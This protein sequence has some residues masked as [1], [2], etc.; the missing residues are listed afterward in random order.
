MDIPSSTTPPP[1]NS[2]S[3]YSV[4]MQKSLRKIAL[5]HLRGI[6]DALPH[7]DPG[8]AGVGHGPAGVDAVRLEVGGVAHARLAALEHVAAGG[9]GVVEDVS[10]GLGVGDAAYGEVAPAVGDGGVLGGEDEQA[11]DVAHVDGGASAAQAGGTA[12]PENRFQ[13]SLE[14]MLSRALS[15]GR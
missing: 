10:D 6:D 7:A 13:I 4:D 11:R 14:P 9:E 12:A 15:A 8:A 5:K 2:F 3:F 1:P